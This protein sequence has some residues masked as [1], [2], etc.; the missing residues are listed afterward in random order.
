MTANLL[1]HFFITSGVFKS[2]FI[3]S[4]KHLTSVY[5]FHTSNLVS[6]HLTVWPF[7]I[8][9][10]Q[11]AIEKLNELITFL[12]YQKLVWQWQKNLTVK[13]L[14]FRDY[15]TYLIFENVDVASLD[16]QLARFSTASEILAKSNF[17]PSSREALPRQLSNQTARGCQHKTRRLLQ[18]KQTPRRN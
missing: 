15:C 7:S 16:R 11:D 4:T 14:C 5:G 6:L 18:I 12:V 17:N 10:V 2:F 3:G 1:G 9:C 13:F 8:P